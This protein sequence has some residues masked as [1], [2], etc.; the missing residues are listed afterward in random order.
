MTYFGKDAGHK[1]KI[2]INGT[3]IA[4]PQL[5]ETRGN[6]FFEV[7]YTIPQELAASNEILTVRFEAEEGS[8][9][10]GIYGVRLLSVPATKK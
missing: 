6:D 2:M 9:T 8:T 1:F 7:D 4:E 3:A 5:K 10:A